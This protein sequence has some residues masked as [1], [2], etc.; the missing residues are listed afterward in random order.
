METDRDGRRIREYVGVAGTSTN[1]AGGVTPWRT[2]LTC[3]ETE[4]LAGQKGATKD[5]GYVFEVDPYHPGNNRDPQPI[6][7]LDRF[8]HEAVAVDPTSGD[9]YLTE[10]AANPNGLLYRWQTP[11]QLR[12]TRP[13]ALRALVPTAGTLA[14]MS[15]ADGAGAHVDDLS[16]ATEIGTSY[17]VSWV[18]VPDR[19]AR[20]TS[21]REQT[22]QRRHHPRT[23]AGGLL[24]GQ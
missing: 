17:T 24:V 16:R 7:A 14:A 22:G 8:A 21:T 2:W 23:Q 18:P 3:E 1:F 20:T 9:L 6:K 10:D 11:P 12:P 19:D 5:H 13:G 4:I 15:C